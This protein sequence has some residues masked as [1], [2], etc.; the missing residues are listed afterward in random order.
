MSLMIKEIQEQPE[1]LERTIQTESGKLKKLGIFLHKKDIDLIVL[2]A[3]IGKTVRQ[4]SFGN[5][6]GKFQ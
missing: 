6:S 1:V 2:V 3:R 4:H 5:M